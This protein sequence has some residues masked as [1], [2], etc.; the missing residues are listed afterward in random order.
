MAMGAPHPISCVCSHRVARFQLRFAQ[1]AL[2][3][4]RQQPERSIAVDHRGLVV[5]AE[6]EAALCEVISVLESVYGD[7]LFVGEITIQYRHGAVVEEPHM[8]VRVL[9][10][11]AQFE[12]VK[13][14]LMARAAKIYDAEVSPPIGVVRATVA[15]ARLLGYSQYLSGLTGG[16]AREVVWLSHY[17]P[18]EPVPPNGCAA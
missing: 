9:C 1:Q 4:F 17:A 12:A 15:L 10:P 13:D 2:Q 7:D 14:D 5:S 6:T 16:K 3:F 11:A 18:V 8:G